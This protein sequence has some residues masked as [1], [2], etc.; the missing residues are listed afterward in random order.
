MGW[1]YFAL[2]GF[3]VGILSNIEEYPGEC[4]WGGKGMNMFQDPP[5]D[6]FRAVEESNSEY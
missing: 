5:N 3:N 4:A 2:C 1:F 6:L